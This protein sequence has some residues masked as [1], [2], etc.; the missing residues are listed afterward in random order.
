MTR[1][2]VTRSVNRGR[3][4]FF[5]VLAIILLSELFFS[6]LG[7]LQRLETVAEELGLTPEAERNRL[8]TL[9][10]FGSMAALGSLLCAA[11]QLSN[12]SLAR[13]GLP[14]T[15]LG[16]VAYGLYQVVSALTQLAPAWRLPIALVGLVY[17]AIGVVAWWVGRGLLSE[18]S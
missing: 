11:A 12:R 5:V 3:L 4:L 9:I 16:L 13:I 7:S 17:A 18:K 6:D 1:E 10:F 15:V 14:L 8:W 2:D